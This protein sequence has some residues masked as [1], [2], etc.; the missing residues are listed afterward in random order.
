ML[1]GSR[2]QNAAPSLAHLPSSRLIRLL[3]SGMEASSSAVAVSRRR[4]HLCRHDRARE[5]SD[6]HRGGPGVRREPSAPSSNGLFCTGAAERGIRGTTMASGGCRAVCAIGWCRGSISDVGEPAADG[7]RGNSLSGRRTSAVA[8]GSWAVDVHGVL[9]KEPRGQRYTDVRSSS[10][11][12]ITYL[13]PRN[14]RPF[15]SLAIVVS[16]GGR[17]SSACACPSHDGP[18]GSSPYPPS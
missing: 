2:I 3:R 4:S 18:S 12:V 13:P 8:F 11:E 7:R 9:I 5:R 15:P 1:T 17:A 6:G 10:V 14:W 16:L